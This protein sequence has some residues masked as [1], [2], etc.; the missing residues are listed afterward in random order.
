MKR[1]ETRRQFLVHGGQLALGA[2]GLGLGLSG[3]SSACASRVVTGAKPGRDVVSLVSVRNG[4]IGAAVEEAIE[5]LGGAA[6][7][8]RGKER[9]LLKP[10]LVSDQSFATTSPKVVEALARLFQR[11]GKDVSIGEGS[12]A[13]GGFNVVGREVF[14]AHKGALL[15]PM[16]RHVFEALGYA[17]LSKRL[18][19]PLVNLHVGEMVTVPVPGGLAYRELQ[20][21]RALVDTDLLCSVPMM[22]THGLATVT[23]GMKNLIGLYS[24]SVYGTVRAAV[25]DHAA[26][27]GSP[28]IAWEI[29][30]MVRANK[31]GLVVVDGSTAME[32]DG[33]TE[34]RLVDMGLIVAGTNPL[35]TDMVAAAAMGIGA[36]EVPQFTAAHALGMRPASLDEIE[37][38]GAK[39]EAVRINFDRPRMATWNQIRHFWA[40]KEM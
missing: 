40:T 15:E 12:A 17:D 35:A 23:L 7:V 5:L 32:G 22:K 8:A 16:Q 4:N 20:L 21:H 18:S 26:D 13:A 3:L 37:L 10:N 36:K 14:R 25:H 34:G 33:P 19:V 38:R 39:L 28:G 29:L 30:D 6:A 31:L 27:A 11:A 24:G 1:H 9:V 2:A